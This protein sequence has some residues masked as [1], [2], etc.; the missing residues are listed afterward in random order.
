[1]FYGEYDHSV[2]SK[3]RFSVPSKC[4]DN[5]GTTFMITKGFDG[6]LFVFAMEK[7]E[8]F[9]KDLSNLPMSRSDARALART[10]AAG[11]SECELDKQGRTLIPVKLRE[12]ADLESEVKIVGVF[13]RLELWDPKKYEEVM[14]DKDISDK[15]MEIK[16]SEFGI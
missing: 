1:M 10:F 9:V 14:G 16:L 5:L 12:Y 3:G 13:D 11:A 7:W 6:C 8:D 15:E 4:R 2:D